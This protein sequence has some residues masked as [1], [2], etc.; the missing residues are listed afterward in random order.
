[1][2]YLEHFM[3]LLLLFKQSILYGKY[4]MVVLIEDS[5]LIILLVVRKA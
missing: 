2:T 3:D 5:S 1:M 4:N